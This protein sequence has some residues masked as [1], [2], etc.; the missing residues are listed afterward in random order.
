MFQFTSGK[1]GLMRHHDSE[2]FQTVVVGLSV[3]V[4]LKPDIFAKNV[5]GVFRLGKAMVFRFCVYRN[6]RR[7]Q[8]I[9]AQ[10]IKNKLL[11]LFIYL[12]PTQLFVTQQPIVPQK[13]QTTFLEAHKLQ[14]TKMSFTNVCLNSMQYFIADKLSTRSLNLVFSFFS[15]RPTALRCLHEE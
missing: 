15:D 2:V 11:F 10:K 7:N 12:P 9:V 3:S 4:C 1:P 5:S 8:F 6:R 14:I 13:W